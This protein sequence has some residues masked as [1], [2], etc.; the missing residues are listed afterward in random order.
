M[1]ISNGLEYSY[2][3]TQPPTFGKARA[4]EEERSRNPFRK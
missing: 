1:A 3:F 4:E 2:S